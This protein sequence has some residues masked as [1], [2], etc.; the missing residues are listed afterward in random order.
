MTG[1]QEA[2]G[3]VITGRYR[4]LRRLG[5]GGMGR[6]WLAYDQELAC[7]VALKEIILLPDVPECEVSSRIA[8]ARGEAR[9]AA[10]L[11]NHPHVVTVHDIVEEDGLPWIVMEYVIGAMDLEAVVREQGPLPPRDVARIGLAVLDALLEGHRLGVLH[12]DVKPANILLTHPGPQPLY[13]TEGGGQVMLTDYGIALEPS[14]GEDRLT[15]T[16]ELLGTPR[17]MAPERANSQPPTPAADLFSLGATLYYALE[18]AGPFDRDTALTTLSALL[19][20]PCTPPRRAMELTPVLV[21]LLAKTPADRMDGEEAAR[22]LASIADQPYP[23]PVQQPAPSS[24]V[25]P[26]ERPPASKPPRPQESAP[27]TEILS[28]AKPEEPTGPPPEPL[29][30]K[31]DEARLRPRPPRP[32][33]RRARLIAGV[34]LATLAAAG[35][36]IYLAQSRSSGPTAPSVS[37]IQVG[38]LPGGV[39]VSPNGR[40]AYA[41]NYF[42]P[43]SV[44][45]ID[46]TTNRTVGNPIPV[47]DKPQGVAVSPDGRRAYTANYGSA[48]VSV[49]DTATNRTVGNPIGVGK[50][51]VGVVVSPDGRWV[52]VANSGSASV[53]VIDTATNRTVGNP[54]GVGKKPYGVAVS[55]DGGRA[56]TANAGSD[57]VSVI[58]TAT[59]RTVGNPIGVG[60]NP[61]GVAVSQD[62]GRAYTANAGSDSVSVIDTATNRT[63]GNP[64]GVGNKPVGVAVSQGGGRAYA[65]NAGSDSVSVIDTATNRTVG[66]PIGVDRYPVGVAVSR[67]GGRAY[68]ANSGSASVSVIEF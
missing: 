4:L 25:P 24:E 8:R 21:G 60:K 17:F 32:R 28:P 44:S 18:G 38:N 66:N 1:A 62:G 61:V 48:S 63:V 37:S 30:R 68:T 20:E 31:G 9:H 7:E 41:T 42:G 67:D 65:A 43:A 51:P 54:I 52:Y 6:V 49:I 23:S 19:F 26:P 10:R 40:R 14:S 53:S 46:T 13:P 3:R 5:T 16:L 47:G 2:A 45:V 33:K 58:D 35:G 27:P 50:D 22:R 59:N 29:P 11:R 15:A 57:S 39:A 12:R 56:Y 36:G 64:I 34:A 55:E